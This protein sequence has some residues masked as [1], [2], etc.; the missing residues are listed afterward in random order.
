MSEYQYYEFATVDHPLTSKQQAELRERSSR[1]TITSH[2]FTNEYHWGDLKGDPLDWMERY[3]D[4]HLYSASWGNCHLLLRLPTAAIDREFFAKFSAPSAYNMKTSNWKAFA[5]VQRGGHWIFSW[6]FNDDSGESERFWSEEDGPGWM[7]RLLPLRDELLRGDSRPLYLG[8]LARVGNCELADEDIEPPL[9]PG[10]QTLTPAQMA[11]AEFLE[12]DPDCLTAAASASPA[13]SEDAE[14]NG[15]LDEWLAEQSPEAM[16]ASLRLLL[17]GQHLEAERRLR[18]HF[19]AWQQAR[20][21]PSA[22]PRQRSVAEIDSTRHAATVSRIKR[23]TNERVMAESRRQNE[24]TNR[25]KRLAENAETIWQGIDKTLQ[26]A[27]AAAYGQ[28]LLTVSELA[29]ALAA[30]G[31]D[32]EFRQGLV[33]C[34]STH[35]KRPAW[36]S[37]LRKAG[38]LPE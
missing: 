20:Q 1:A 38:F 6:S 24:R 3:F 33:R 16:R 19:L 17:G 37:R 31:R 36:I 35:G 4:A 32:A 21:T 22:K 9:P 18:Q 7:A 10:L 28:A 11:L 5:V 14:A 13:I 27:S 15:K 26:K 34:L 25:L 8:W 23:E 12:I 30:E 29:E 2:G